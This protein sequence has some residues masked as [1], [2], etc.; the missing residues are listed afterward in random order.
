[1]SGEMSWFKC[2][3]FVVP[4]NHTHDMMKLNRGIIQYM[5]TYVKSFEALLEAKFTSHPNHHTLIESLH[6][7]II[8]DSL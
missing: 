3:F 4:M 6:K 7:S 5:P 8:F 1:M 2:I